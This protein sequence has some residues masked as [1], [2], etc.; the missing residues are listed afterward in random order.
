MSESGFT[1]R[2]KTARAPRWTIGVFAIIL[3]LVSIRPL[4]AQLS[5]TQA[6]DL[7]KLP[8]T[9]RFVI[10]RFQGELKLDGLS[11]EPG[12][13]SIRPFPFIQAAPNF[14]AEPTE[15]T[16]A[17]LA[18]DDEFLYVAGRLYDREPD[19]IQAP[20][21]KRDAMVAN[22]EWFG[23]SIDTFND[24][25]N[26]LLFLTTPSGLRFDGAVFND[27]QVTDPTDPGAVPLNLS[28][29]TFWDVVS[30]RTKDG[31]FV[32]MR[33]PLSSI[34]FENK[35]GRTV[36]GISFMRWIT[37]KNENMVFPAIPPNWG[38]MSFWKPSQAQEIEFEG[39][40]QRRPLYVTPYI[41]GG[42]SRTYDLNE[43]ETAYLRTDTPKFDL[44]LDVKY[45]LT[46]NL[47]LDLTVNTDFAQV[48]ADDAQVNLTRFSL[49]FPEKRLFFQERSSNFDFN[50][51]APNRLFY[52]RRIGL[53]DD[54]PVRIYGG[55]RVVGRVG[56]WDLGFLDMQTEALE[57]L[58]SENFGVLRL[59]R[60]VINPYSYVGGIVTSR[61]G[62]NGAHNV[63]YG[64][65]G[66]FRPFGDDYIT[67]HWAQTYETD[68]ANK[69]FS[70]NPSWIDLT[71]ERRTRKGLGYN[72]NFSRAGQDFDPGMGFMMRENYTRFEAR[73][74]Y[75]W[76][77]GEKSR[78]FSHIINL[79]GWAIVDNASKEVDSVEFGPGWEFS[80]KSGWSGMIGPRLYHENVREEFSFSEDTVIP[81]GQYSFGGLTSYLVTPQG[82]LLSGIFFLDGGT[83]YDGRRFTAGVIPQ[84]SIVPD[85]ELSGML[86]Y[87]YVT[88]P[89]RSQKLIAPLARIRLLWTLSTKFSASALV[90]YNGGDDAAVINVRLRFNPSEGTDVYLVYNEGLNADRFRKTPS[91][92]S[93]SDRTLVLKFNYTFNF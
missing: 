18:Y 12:W 67:F 9:Q 22:T 64:L 23:I 48:E 84:W 81:V 66:I 1:R 79:S 29:N 73:G 76:F 26:A 15:R 28:W 30:A 71:W 83:F 16:E 53:S 36:M 7:L 44:G 3:G 68:A 41:L 13:Q 58:P 50:L 43:A 14:G 6:I 39:L 46:S 11:D 63:A 40:V 33:I 2:A 17:L 24:K 37:R 35:D 45:G 61:V 86:Q 38:E 70:M 91:L 72:F 31:W 56:G 85:V 77:P 90:Q 69:P 47:T 8:R 34:R 74:L 88:F 25:E 92:P 59:R 57:D 19:K 80:T 93:T 20:T 60:R 21:K 10:P 51:L 4:T 75:G 62:R 78:L 82:N 42:A 32:E 87:N 52:S 27:A 54:K 5:E 65:D 55:A 89:G 49:F